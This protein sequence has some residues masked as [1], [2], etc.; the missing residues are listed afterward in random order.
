MTLHVVHFNPLVSIF[1]FLMECFYTRG[2]HQQIRIVSEFGQGILSVY[3]GWRPEAGTTYDDGPIPEP[4]M[5]NALIQATREDISG[6]MHGW[7]DPFP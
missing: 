6:A 4:W 2:A 5:M 7:N 3:L 1:V